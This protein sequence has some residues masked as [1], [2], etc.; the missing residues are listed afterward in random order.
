MK[1]VSNQNQT[2]AAKEL[3]AVSVGHF[4]VDFYFSLIPPVIFLFAVA[5][6]LN[7]SQQALIAFVIT[8]CGSFAQPIIGYFADKSGKPLQVIL[9]VVWIAFWMS[10][11][12]LVNNYYVLLVTV[13]LG[14]LGSALFHPLGT[15]MTVMLARKSKGRTLSVFMSIGG[16]A[17][18]ASPMIA[19]PLVEAYGLKVLVFFMIPGMLAAAFMFYAGVH[20]VEMEKRQESKVQKNK[21]INYFSVKWVCVLVFIAYN[22]TMVRTFL[23]TFG[24]QIILTRSEERRVG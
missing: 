15:A 3:F 10:I 6:K 24:A 16:F 23:I 20:K 1:T 17:F 8:G 9:S 12:G 5:M 11:S 14:A 4:F 7:L 2:P 21:K 22:K 18:S 19:I 13:G